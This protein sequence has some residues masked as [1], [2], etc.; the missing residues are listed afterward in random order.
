MYRR[1]R[2][3]TATVLVCLLLIGTV[4]C[5]RSSGSEGSEAPDG[6]MILGPYSADVAVHLGDVTIMVT[7]VQVL[8][9]TATAGSFVYGLSNRP[10]EAAPEGSRFVDITVQV[11]DPARRYFEAGGLFT[12]PVVLADGERVEVGERARSG[13]DSPLIEERME[14]AVPET[15]R[16][17]VLQLPLSGESTAVPSFRLW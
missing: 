4:A 17:V 14:F 1:T 13:G 10:G 5:T 2:A 16:D 8:E 12:S 9:A 6:P 15:A 3:L 7:D 11:D